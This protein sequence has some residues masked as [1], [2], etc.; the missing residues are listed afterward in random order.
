[1]PALHKINIH[2]NTHT[3]ARID[4]ARWVKYMA[5]KWNF[6]HWGCWDR[7]NHDR[8]I[9]IEIQV[10]FS[11]E[12]KTFMG[13]WKNRCWSSYCV[14]YCATIVYVIYAVYVW[15]FLYSTLH[16][17]LVMSF[18]I[19]VDMDAG[20]NGIRPHVRTW[21]PMLI[22]SYCKAT[23]QSGL[24]QVRNYDSEKSLCLLFYYPPIRNYVTCKWF[25]YI[26]AIFNFIMF[27]CLHWSVCCV[28]E[29]KEY[30]YWNFNKFKYLKLYPFYLQPH[31]LYYSIEDNF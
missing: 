24:Y 12:S 19:Q 22:L 2:T 23:S 28:N 14:A 9:A 20:T 25:W 4:S 6:L 7:R 18:S 8:Y 26:L 5:T 27:S 31:N 30:I 17:I 3:N 16:N 11:I 21:K 10:C 13:G 1:M 29:N 15:P